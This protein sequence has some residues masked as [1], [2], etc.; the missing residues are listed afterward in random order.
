MED[1]FSL[2]NFL[3]FGFV[4]CMMHI[5]GCYC[6]VYRKGNPDKIQDLTLLTISAIVLS[7]IV[8]VFAFFLEKSTLAGQEKECNNAV[9]ENVLIIEG[10]C[11]KSLNADEYVPFHTKT[12]KLP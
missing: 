4:F 5:A 11:Y 12:K 3:I 7:F 10:K 8:I 2:I 9:S 6:G 1:V